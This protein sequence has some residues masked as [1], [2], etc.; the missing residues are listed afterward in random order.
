[1]RRLSFDNTTK[2]RLRHK[3]HPDFKK[4]CCGE[5]SWKNKIFHKDFHYQFFFNKFV[6]SDNLYQET[7]FELQV[8]MYC[9]FWLNIKNDDI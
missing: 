9:F 2:V 3:K 1:M 4:L 5:A 8:I 6:F 7:K